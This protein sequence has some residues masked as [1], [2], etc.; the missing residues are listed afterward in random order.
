[1]KKRII[2]VIII[3]TF[4]LAAVI[5]AIS[6]YTD[7]RSEIVTDKPTGKSD[8]SDRQVVK[9]G[10][11]YPFSGNG[12][13]YGDTAKVVIRQFFEEFNKDNHKY[14]YQVLLQDN[15]SSPA[16]SVTLAHRFADA[17]KVDVLVT[18]Q[19]G[20][21]L[22]VASAVQNADVIH[23]ANAADSKIVRYKR[24]LLATSDP[25]L[26]GK[27]LYGQLVKHGAK[28]VDVVVENSS[29]MED[30]FEHFDRE[31]EAGGELSIKNIFRLND[32][33]RDLRIVLA[34]IKNDNPD[35]VVLMIFKP[36]ADVFLRQY[37]MAQVNIPLA[38]ADTFNFLSDKSLA[39]GMWYVDGSAATGDFR[40]RILS[41]TGSNATYF[42]EHLDAIL[43]IVTWAYETSGMVDKE[44][45]IEYIINN[46]TGMPT[47]I[48]VIKTN[49]D[50]IIA[51]RM[52]VRKVQGGAIVGV[53]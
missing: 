15:L 8:K 3:F 30:W 41:E 50:G 1:M 39:E 49:P 31:V 4:T 42:G 6:A 12:A 25:E 36:L 21:S 17:E 27:L 37:K 51:G 10:V 35:Y 16:T 48:G 13:V 14:D 43:Q 22:A 38:G 11:I 28:T 26:K 2:A 23:F 33:E 18:F 46:S 9:I 47:S 45:I 52:V 40:A 34:K 32:S 19:S 24:S 7:R 20:P 53:D 5:C 44:E 29:G